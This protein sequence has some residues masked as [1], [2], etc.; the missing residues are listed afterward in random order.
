MRRISLESYETLKKHADRIHQWPAW[1]GKA[2]KFIRAE[3]RDA[4]QPLAQQQRAWGWTQ[5]SRDHSLLVQIF[6]WERDV[7][8]AW[9]EAQAGGCHDSWWMELTRSREKQFPADVVPI[10]QKQVDTSSN[11]V[12]LRFSSAHFLRSS[13]PF[14]AV[15]HGFRIAGGSFRL[16]PRLQ[17]FTF[18]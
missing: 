2:L 6:L 18:S 10:Y 11:F 13:D 1:R 5:Y 16:R 7:E 14:Q 9:R 8:A 4:K 17:L 15:S 3:V 12:V